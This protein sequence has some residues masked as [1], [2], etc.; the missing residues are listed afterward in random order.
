MLQKNKNGK[1]AMLKCF[2]T[3][4][5]LGILI[6]AF[7]HKIYSQEKPRVRYPWPK[8]LAAIQIYSPKPGVTIAEIK[9]YSGRTIKADIS[10]ESKRI[11]IEKKYK[12]N[13]DINKREEAKALK[14]I[15]PRINITEGP[16][17]KNLTTIIGTLN[18]GEDVYYATVS[19]RNGKRLT[20]DISTPEKR[21]ELQK[22]F[23][24]N[25]PELHLKKI[26]TPR[27]IYISVL[28]QQEMPE[29]LKYYN[30]SAIGEFNEPQILRIPVTENVNMLQL[31]SMTEG[32]TNQANLKTIKV[33]RRNND[34]KQ[35]NT[36]DLTSA[37]SLKSP[38]YSLKPNDIVIL[39][40]VK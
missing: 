39:D 8:D 20:F 18:N 11:S 19:F 34:N 9:Y 29:D 31:L 10:T 6:M 7:S 22:R 23:N 25:L 16:T 32:V 40:P 37:N 13:I 33:I 2:L 26:P 1:L 14:N 35:I 24:V 38:Y 4:P 27:L 30:I 12:V 36:V 3:V 5:L 17:P 15:K 21:N 28:E